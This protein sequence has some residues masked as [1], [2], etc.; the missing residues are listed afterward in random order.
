MDANLLMKSKIQMTIDKDAVARAVRK[1]LETYYA[2]I[3][4][5]ENEDFSERPGDWEENEE[6]F[7]SI[8]KSPYVNSRLDWLYVLELIYEVIDRP[9]Q[10]KPEQFAIA[11]EKAVAAT[12]GHRDYLAIVPM[13]FKSPFGFFG[14]KSLPPRSMQV[15]QFTLSPAADSKQA[16]NKIIT[17]HGFPEIDESDFQHASKTSRK[18]FSHEML[19]S[20]IA[21]G[22]EERLRFSV[23]LQFRHMARLVELFACLFA[24]IASPL[25]TSRAANHLFLLSKTTGELRRLPSIKPLSIDFEL[26]AGLL[27]SIKRPEFDIFFTD[28]SSSTD[29]M[30]GRLRN[31]IKFFS[32]ALNSE[33]DATSFLF[34][35]VAVESI[36]S[37]DKNNPIKATL[38]ELGSMLCFPPKQRLDAYQTIRKAYDLRSSIVHAGA[39]S[40]DK[41]NVGIVR[42]IAARAIYSS[43]YLCTNLKGGQ[44]KLEDRFFNHLRDQKLGVAKAI[45]PRSIWALPEIGTI[46]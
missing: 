2:N 36:F 3:G 13:A 25:A 35:V 19:A 21:H 41:K 7:K 14:R 18:A 23:E 26:S 15:G 33:D 22:T 43:L 16:L 6:L 9:E 30:H 40:V 39:S 29:S 34:Y 46:D 1:P 8:F 44:G 12:A 24:D 10:L 17:R 32:M 4:N 11:L 5:H 31:A 38:A 37:R 42:S 27:K 45:I 28:I 20:F